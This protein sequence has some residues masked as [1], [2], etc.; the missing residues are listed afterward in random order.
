[1]TFQDYSTNWVSDEPGGDEDPFN[2]SESEMELQS[3]SFGE[4]IKK[5]QNPKATCE[6]TDQNPLVESPVPY[7]HS[8]R[9]YN[10]RAILDSLKF[11]KIFS[12]WASNILIFLADFSLKFLNAFFKLG[13][14]N[15]QKIL[16][17]LLCSTPFQNTIPKQKNV[18]WW[19]PR[20]CNLNKMLKYAA[21]S[22]I[23]IP[24]K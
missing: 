24:Y 8:V 7:L 18:C 22:T 1:M 2:Q 20:E 6:V 9:F 11:L 17:C 23:I 10:D 19:C 21:V 3:Q 5:C 12:K 15:T 4:P 13:V 14:K 16:S